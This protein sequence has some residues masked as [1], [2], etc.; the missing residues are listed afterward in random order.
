MA[1]PRDV[2]VTYSVHAKDGSN[3]EDNQKVADSLR[4]AIR[5]ATAEVAVDN[6]ETTFKDKMEINHSRSREQEKTKFRDS[7]RGFFLKFKKEHDSRNQTNVYALSLVDG[8]G[9]FDLSLEENE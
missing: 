5:E 8:L 6:I 4:R 2:L 1:N 3:F 9:Y 7:M